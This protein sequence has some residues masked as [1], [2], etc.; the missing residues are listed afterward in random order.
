VSAVLAL[1]GFVAARVVE[2]PSFGAAVSQARIL[3]MVF[4]SALL[5]LFLIVRKRGPS[6][7]NL[8]LFMATY[9]VGLI[10]W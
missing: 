5:V 4:A 1:S 6:F 2:I 10:R 8:M 7:A 3:A 9:L